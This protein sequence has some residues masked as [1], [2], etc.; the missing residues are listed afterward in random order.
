MV[1]IEGKIAVSPNE[2][3]ELM[4]CSRRWVE[5]RI[6][7]GELRSLKIA[8]KRLVLVSDLT[9]FLGGNTADSDHQDAEAA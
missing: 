6:R 7:S 4:P 9:A 8:G 5:R 3:T 2:I 1:T